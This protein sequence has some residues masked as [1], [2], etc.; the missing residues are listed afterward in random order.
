[1]AA[2]WTAGIEDIYIDG[3]FCTEK[4]DPGDVDGYW[5]EPDGGVYDRIDPY[6][7]DFELILVP[8]VRKWKWRMWADYG[9]EF[10]IHPGMRAS[11]TAQFPEFFRQDREGL[12]RGVIQVV[13]SES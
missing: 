12:P 5:V 6:W 1:M 8:Q 10:F 3:S 2:F 4:P 9:V 11:P 7:I 13:R